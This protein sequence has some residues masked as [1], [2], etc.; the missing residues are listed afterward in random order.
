MSFAIKPV[1]GLADAIGT[2]A[3]TLRT[4]QGKMFALFEENG[5]E[6]V[7]PPIID[8][9]E[10][11]SSGAG[12]FLADQTLVFSDP[13]DTGLLAIRS[14]M[15]PQIARIAATRLQSEPVLKLCYSGTV[16][17]AR[18]DARTASRQQWQMGVEYLGVAD[19]SCDIE[20]MHLAAMAMHRAGFREPVLQVGHIG[21][22]KALV[23]G[24]SKP[25]EFWAALLGRRSPDD[26][27]AEIGKGRIDAVCG[28]ALVT[29]ASGLADRRWLEAEA[30][31]VNPA[32]DKAAG[33]LLKLVDA[34]AERLSG[35]VEVCIDAAVTP[36]FFYHNGIVFSG[37]AAEASQA[38]LHGGRYDEMM[39]AH[40]RD[41]PATGF[42]F[43]LWA[44][45]DAAPNVSQD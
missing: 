6:E 30:G 33:E 41:M 35:E 20:V 42:S 28:E 22:L 40:G 38:L 13:A 18:P 10:T 45:M 1:L 26:V 25:V 34:V 44:W 19:Q 31:K 4:L 11:L 14:D 16:I 23:S 9:P 39:A 12:R 27:R 29:M 8:R 5:F 17:L 21:L 3:K 7:I 37:F 32:F 2:R 15:T 24:S 36:R 43:D